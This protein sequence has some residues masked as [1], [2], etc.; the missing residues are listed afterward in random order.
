MMAVS[1]FGRR[2]SFS[3]TGRKTGLI[4]TFCLIPNVEE[5]GETYSRK[6][7]MTHWNVIGSTETIY[8]SLLHGPSYQKFLEDWDVLFR[9][10]TQC[11]L[12]KGH[13]LWR[14]F[15]IFSHH[16]CLRSI[17]KLIQLEEP[18]FADVHLRGKDDHIR[19]LPF[20]DAVVAAISSHYPKQGPNPSGQGHGQGAPKGHPYSSRHYRSAAEACSQRA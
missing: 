16:F 1:I 18:I 10:L 2:S 4:H 15:F 7:F 20:S 12:S 9:T 19:L 11:G 8:L 17:E 14:N 13:T 3:K 5:R 6:K